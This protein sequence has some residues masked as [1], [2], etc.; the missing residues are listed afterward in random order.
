MFGLMLNVKLRTN[1]GSSIGPNIRLRTNVGSSI[2]PNVLLG[3]IMSL[4]FEY[5]FGVLLDG[6]V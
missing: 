2:W 6:G 3:H 1:I 4:V 5:L